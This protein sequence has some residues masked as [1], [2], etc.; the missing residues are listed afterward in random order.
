MWHQWHGINERKLSMYRKNGINGM[1]K[2]A[3][4]KIMA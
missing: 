2:M 3:S 4:S 1:A